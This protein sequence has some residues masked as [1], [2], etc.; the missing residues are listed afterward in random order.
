M[1][2]IIN[3][4][5][6]FGSMEYFVREKQRNSEDLT[7]CHCCDVYRPNAEVMTSKTLAGHNVCSDCKQSEIRHASENEDI[8]YLEELV[9]AKF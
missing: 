6:Q 7:L 2:I 9:N 5:P 8:A 1:K 3:E 4:A